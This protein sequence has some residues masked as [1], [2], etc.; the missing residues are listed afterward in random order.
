MHR[1]RT[2]FSVCVEEFFELG[3]MNCLCSC[4]GLYQ[5]LLI[6]FFF[7]FTF[8]LCWVWVH[9]GIYKRSHNIPNTWVHPLHYSPLSPSPHSWSSFNRSHFS[10]YIQEYTVFAPYAPSHTL[11]SHPPPSHWYQPPG[12][13]CTALQFIDFVKEKEKKKTF[14][15]KTATWFPYDISMCVCI[16]TS[17]GAIQNISGVYALSP[18]CPHHFILF[19]LE[20]RKKESS[21][22]VF[23][24]LDYIAQV[25]FLSF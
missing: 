23:F 9:C 1:Y 7:I 15:F 13:T 14:V 4:M 19:W 5:V 8:L 21:E 2:L 24:R 10:I 25:L 18:W 6:L 20:N 22:K 3:D 16:I 17:Y 11:S 12:R